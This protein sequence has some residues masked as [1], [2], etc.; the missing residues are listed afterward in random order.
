MNK[1][2]RCIKVEDALKA[3]GLSSCGGPRSSLAASRG[4]ILNKSGTNMSGRASRAEQPPLC[5]PLRLGGHTNCRALAA[6]QSIAA[7]QRV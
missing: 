3:D 7:R 5:K 6:A 1:S 2:V 4:L